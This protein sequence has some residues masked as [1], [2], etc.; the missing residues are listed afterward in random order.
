MKKSK[1]RNSKSKK[2]ASFGKIAG[3]EFISKLIREFPSAEAYLVG[4]A[5]RDHILVR[6]TKD[7][8]FVVRGVKAKE[9]EKFLGRLGDVDLVGRNFGVF[10]F[11][12]KGRTE[13]PYDIALP[14]TEHSTGDG[15]YRNFDVQSDPKLPIAEDLSRRDFTINA[16]AYKLGVSGKEVVVSEIVDPW[17]GAED[18]AKRI[19]RTVGEPK[20]RFVEDYSRLLRALRFS[21]QLGFDLEDKTYSALR[22]LMAQ[23]N[24]KNKGVRVTPTETIAREFLKS[25]VADP[26][27]TFDLWDE[28]GAFKMLMPELLTMKKCEQPEN[29]HAEGDVWAH[30]RLALS[31]PTSGAYR[32][33][34][35]SGAPSAE[36][37]LAL[38]LHDVGKP[39]T[40][41]TPKEHGTDRVRFNNHDA[42]GAQISEDICKRLTFSAPAEFAV[43]A[44]RIANI[45]RH[46]LI[47]VHGT[48]KELRQTTIEKYFFRPSFPG[49]ALEQVIFCDSSATMPA[50]GGKPDLKHFFELRDRIAELKKLSSQKPVLPPPLLDGVEIMKILKMAPGPEVG[51]IIN[52][53]REEQLGGKLKTAVEAKRFLI[54]KNKK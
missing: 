2:G 11:L 5:V 8:D 9:L 35:G 52:I 47:T 44:E 15:G 13:E 41:Q 1:S 19:I 40:K 34:Y 6:H 14:R 29:F 20:E 51:K 3:L 43:D 25:L 26:V 50:G 38:M 46:H 27:R 33:I 48:V 17:K 49:E 28:S 30:T 53:L 24:D 23:I 32:K 42:V 31:V 21:V 54:K 37:L 4:G 22:A 12:P 39:P 7:F 36:M 10:K 16:I 45:V 18:I